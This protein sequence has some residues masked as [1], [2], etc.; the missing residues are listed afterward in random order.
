M[1]TEDR[2]GAQAAAV[3]PA[4]SFSVFRLRFHFHPLSTSDFF[5]ERAEHTL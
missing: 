1:K 3:T 5:G 4:A 2:T